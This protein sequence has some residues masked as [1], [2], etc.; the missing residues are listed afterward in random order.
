MNKSKY[1]QY[2]IQKY[3]AVWEHNT[4]AIEIE[5]ACIRLKGSW[6]NKR[7]ATCG[8]GLYQHMLNLQAMLWPHLDDHRWHRLIQEN[9]SNNQVTVLMGPAS[10]SKTH[11]AA[12]WALCEYFCEPDETI[13]L[14]SSTDI[15]GLELRIWGE[16][17][18][19]YQRAKEIHPDLPGF[20]V[21]SK[22]CI[23]T[24]SIEEDEVR[25]L[26]KGIVGIPCI[27]NNRFIG[28]GKYVGIKQKRVRLVADEAQFMQASFL[29]SIANLDKNPDFKAVIIGNPL[30]PLD[31]LGKAAEPKDGWSSIGEPEKTTT[32]KTR[33]KNGICVN[34]VGLDSPNFDYPEDKEPRFPYLIHQKSI[35]NTVAF[36]GKDS[37]QYYSQCKGVMKSGL[38]A[39]RVITRELCSKFNAQESAIWGGSPTTKIY[40]LDAAYGMIGGDRCVGIIVEF[41]KDVQGKT[42]LETKA[43]EIIPVSYK[44]TEMPED[45]IVKYVKA[46]CQLEGID[47]GFVYHDATGRGSLG[48][49][50]AR[51]WSAEVNAVEFGGLPSTRTVCQDLFILDE[52]TKRKRLKLCSEH[53]SKFVSELWYSVRYTIESGQMRGLTDELMEEGCMREWKIVRGNRIEIESKAETK[54]R[55]GRSPDLFDALCTAVEGARRRGFQ[56]SRMASTQSKQ[57]ALEFMERLQER[58]STLHKLHEL[59]YK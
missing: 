1:V 7:G 57:P 53:Y 50:F 37:L 40:G 51:L 21:D 55:M 41:G 22:H 26:R 33:F 14:M 45:Q 49:S 29:D 43:H 42:I 17:K 4:P 47:P 58:I 5:M 44:N 46:K 6:K 38:L 24:D 52:S 18:M 48:T 31:S 15:R 9:I 11:E 27:V 59:T 54:E 34:L 36:Y 23:S 56:I 35:D 10:T 16:I 39:R 32:W 12:K 19:L 13:V 28:L 30:E 3:G 20:L 25:D 8:L 2:H